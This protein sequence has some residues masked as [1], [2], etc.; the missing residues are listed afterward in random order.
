MKYLSIVFLLR[1]RSHYKYF[2]SDP[3]H[4][5]KIIIKCKT[6]KYLYFYIIKLCTSLK[7]IFQNIPLQ[8]NNYDCGVFVC[9]YAEQLSMLKTI[10]KVNTVNMNGFRAQMLRN[11]LE[12]HEQLSTLENAQNVQI[13]EEITVSIGCHQIFLYCSSDV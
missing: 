8:N 9:F 11:I 10:E 2:Y 13:S 12:S 5:V 3:N 6:V 4:Q 1:N 7:W